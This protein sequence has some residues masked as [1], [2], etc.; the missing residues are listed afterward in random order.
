MPLVTTSAIILHAFKYSESSK[1]VRLATEEIGV[2]SAVAKGAMRP[3][4][5]FG[6][7]LQVLSGGLAQIY[8]K[9]NRDL[10]TLSEFDVTQQRSELAR[11]VERYV[12]ATALAELVLR[13]APA[14]PNPTVYH[15]LV[16]TLDDLV[17]IDREDLEPF[18]LAALWGAVGILGFAPAM[19]GC[20]CDGRR[21]PEGAAAFSIADGGFLCATC[22]ASNTSATTIQAQD[23]ATLERLVSGRIDDI[24]VIP[25]RHAAAHRRLLARFV[26]RHMSEDREFKALSMWE[27]MWN[28]T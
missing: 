1:I 23:R 20:A 11:D 13:L 8:T 22:A 21:L 27:G 7:R 16:A 2:Q 26:E 14:E 18:G 6:A 28:G 3:K 17:A 5:K 19:D 24:G 25:P 4:S 10:H 12:T 9:P 15:Y